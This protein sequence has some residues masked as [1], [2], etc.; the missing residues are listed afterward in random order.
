MAEYEYTIEE[1][2][3]QIGQLKEIKLER[4]LL[5]E[6]LQTLAASLGRVQLEKNQVEKE[7]AN[8]KTE[9]DQIQIE[10]QLLNVII[11]KSFADG[12]ILKKKKSIF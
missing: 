12:I 10:S 3:V 11:V 1:L 8:V 2:T 7:T 5:E 9:L 4:G 6:E